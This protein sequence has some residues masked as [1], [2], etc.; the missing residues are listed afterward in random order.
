MEHSPISTSDLPSLLV[1]VQSTGAAALVRVPS[2][3]EV[4]VKKVLHNVGSG[5]L[6]GQCGKG[7]TRAQHDDE[8]A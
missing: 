4:A 6:G 3:D 1:A 8:R 5:L 7:F 2:N